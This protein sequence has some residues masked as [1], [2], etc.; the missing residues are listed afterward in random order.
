MKKSKSTKTKKKHIFNHPKGISFVSKDL[1]KDKF[2]KILNLAKKVVDCKNY[3]STYYFCMYH[4]KRK[5]SKYDFWKEMKENK[6][7][8]A[9]DIPSSTFQQACFDVYDKYFKKKPPKK[10]V[11]FKKVSFTGLNLTTVPM[12]VESDNVYTNGII[13]LNIPKHGII[14]IPFKYSREYHGDLNKIYY[15]RTGYKNS[16]YQ[17]LYRLT[18]N[19]VNH[20]IKISVTE[21]DKNYYE[22]EYN[23]EKILGVDINVSRN[24]FACSDG[25]FIEHDKKLVQKL[26]NHDLR[27]RQIKKTKKKRKLSQDYGRKQ[28]EIAE[29]DNNRAKWHI[30]TKLL[31]IFKYAKKMGYNHLVFE[32]LSPFYGKK[33][34][35]SKYDGINQN[36]L[37]HILHFFDIKNVAIALGKK[38]G[39]LVSTVPAAYTSKGCPICGHIHPDNRK[40]QSHFECIS[41]GYTYDADTNAAINIKQRVS[42]EVLRNQMTT[43]RE[44]QCYDAKDLSCEEIRKIMKEYYGIV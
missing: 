20:T 11:E 2:N 33:Y 32:D 22:L 9:F 41:C 36:E 27:N 15:S 26:I 12:F 23:H 35:K 17:K 39:F 16:Q 8:I 37:M 24:L 10:I 14:A 43:K 7:D 31:Q 3:M 30:I 21:E 18:I 25:Y 40:V 28:E 13:N 44:K 42:L 6:I 38:Y 4:F 29:R 34:I 5:T 1:N 19:K